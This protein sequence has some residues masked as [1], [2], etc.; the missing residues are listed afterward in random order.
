MAA[1][2][3]AGSSS[4]KI[5]RP[6]RSSKAL[7]APSPIERQVQSKPEHEPNKQKGE[8]GSSRTEGRRRVVATERMHGNRW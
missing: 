6:T 1:T 3:T 5:E 2:V 8:T 4:Q 7:S